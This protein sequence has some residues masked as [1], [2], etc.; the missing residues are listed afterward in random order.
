MDAFGQ[1]TYGE[2]IAGVYDEW[3]TTYDPAAVTLLHE[4]AQGGR[5]LELGIGT[6]RIA[7]PLQATGVEVHGVDASPAMVAKLRAKSG[8]DKLPVSLG[9]FADVP[10][11]GRYALIYVLFNTFFA[12]LSQDEQAR[13]FQNVARHLSPSG[14]FAIEV[15]VPDLTR[16]TRRQNVSAVRI[17]L[18]AVRIDAS[19]HDPLLQQVSSQHLV[20]SEQGVRMYPVTLRYAWPSELDLMARLAGLRLRQR[21]ST[22]EKAAFTADSGKHISVYKRV[23]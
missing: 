14:V 8:G 9:N 19:L 15:F 13:C 22:W 23:A 5:A 3:Y 12:L 6:G 17:D 1:E 11:D 20:F 2:R 21:W 4:L 10:V 18:D 7:L 16:F